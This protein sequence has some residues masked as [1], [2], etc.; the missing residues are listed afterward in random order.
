M[1]II[2]MSLKAS[3]SAVLFFH[4]ISWM[5][6]VTSLSQF[7]RVVLATLLTQRYKWLFFI[8]FLQTAL[9]NVLKYKGFGRF[10]FVFV[11]HC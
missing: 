2:E 6:F 1:Y 10:F 5:R 8:L 4:E 11:L 7:L 9:S 3:F